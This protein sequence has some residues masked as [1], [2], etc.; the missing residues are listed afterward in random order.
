[1]FQVCSKP[2]QHQENG[3]VL[4][5]TDNLNKSLYETFKERDQKFR[6]TTTSTLVNVIPNTKS[7]K[8]NFLPTS[9]NSLIEN[10]FQKR[11]KVLAQYRNMASS[12]SSSLSNRLKEER[13]PYLLQH[14]TNPVHWYPWGEDAFKEA[15][16]NN[17]MIFLSVGYSTCHWCHV[18]ERESFESNEVLLHNVL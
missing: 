3:E 5:L 18:M 10:Q 2:N 16:E 4:N 17:K 8:T 14:A 11:P 7:S 9:Q 1:M 13:S 6:Q 15:R 12:T